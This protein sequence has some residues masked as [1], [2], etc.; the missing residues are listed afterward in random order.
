MAA[1]VRQMALAGCLVRSISR[2]MAS[3]RVVARR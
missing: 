3:I 1:M 2:T